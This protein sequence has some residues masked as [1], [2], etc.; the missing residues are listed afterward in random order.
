MASKK[1]KKFLQ[2][3]Q[4]RLQRLWRS[5][6][7]QVSRLLLI[8]AIIILV[9]VV[10]VYLVMRMAERPSAPID[11]PTQTVPQPEYEQTLGNVK[12]VFIDARDQGS[13]LRKADARGQSYSWAKDLTTT[14][15]FIIVTIGAQNK[16]KEN[17][18]ERSW[19]IGDIVDSEGR[20][21]VALDEYDSEPWLPEEN[22][23]QTLLKPEF[24]P[25]PCAKIYEVSKI[26]T[27]LKIIVQ[28]GK[29]NKAL[30]LSS[31]DVEEALIDL[32]VK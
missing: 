26:S 28:T 24:D 13:V 15:R 9:A 31:D 8:L 19:D 30:N 4:A 16:G 5:Q 1:R 29:D 12:F 10:I 25:T 11:E 7:G 14:E 2:K 21:F 32:I 17:I 6:C 23:C 20:R 27:G 18:V 3:G 22:L